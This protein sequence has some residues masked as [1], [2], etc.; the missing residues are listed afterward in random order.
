MLLYRGSNLLLVH[1][2]LSCSFSSHIL[3]ASTLQDLV[4]LSMLWSESLDSHQSR[5][6]LWIIQI[7]QRW[8]MYPHA[9]SLVFPSKPLHTSSWLLDSPLI[10]QD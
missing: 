5:L 2:H 4:I 1:L 8:W 10:D 7:R 6:V 3:V 9:F